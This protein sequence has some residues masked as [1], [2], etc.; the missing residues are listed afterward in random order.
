MD[1]CKEILITLRDY[2]IDQNDAKKMLSDALK[3]VVDEKYNGD[4]SLFMSEE[5]L[6]EDFGS[7]RSEV[8]E[9]FN[10]EFYLS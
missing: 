4:F 9:L 10:N 3:D 8:F 2:L 1:R 6:N 7:L 5:V